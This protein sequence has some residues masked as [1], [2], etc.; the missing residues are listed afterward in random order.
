MKFTQRSSRVAF[1]AAFCL[2]VMV[3]D[4]RAETPAAVCNQVRFQPNWGGEKD[5]VGGKI[6]G[7]NVSSQTGFVTLAEIKEAPKLKEWGEVKF[8]NTKVY[9]Y[10]RVALP[11]EGKGK[12]SKVEFYD[13][14]QLV[15]TDKMGLRLNYFYGDAPDDHIIGYDLREK[16]STRP[17]GFKPGNPDLTGPADVALTAADGAVIRYTL[18]GTMPTADHG[19]IYKTPIHVDQ[20]TTI[21]AVAILP[22]RAPSPPNGVTFLLPA[23]TKQGL[24]VASVGNSLTGITLNFWRYARTAGYKHTTYPFLRGG[25]LTR[26]LW[27][28]T[29]SEYAAELKEMEKT[30]PSLANGQPWDDFW[31]KIRKVD[32][33]T[34]QPRDFD[35]E[36]ETA[37]EVNFLKLFRQ[38]W[39]D[40]QPYLYCEW[41][42]LAR[43]RPSDKGTVPSFEM[44]KTFP[45][46]TWE[47]SMSAMLLYMEELQHRL[48]AAYPEGRPAH[49]IPAALAMG[50][51]KNK[52]DH[53]QF[54][55]AQPGEFYSL[56]FSDQVHPAENGAFL[57]D[58]TWYSMLYREP[59]E[60]KVLPVGTT[61]TPEQ[62]RAME[63][64]AWDVLKHYPDCGFYEEG[65]EP[66]GQPEFANDGRIITLKSSTPGAWFRYTLDGTKPTRTRGYVYCGA[67]S[68][69]P[70]IH[71]QAIAYKSGMADSAVADAGQK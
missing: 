4:S 29:S 30:R 51:V 69:Q 8:D 65:K 15:A 22:D 59:S 45:A 28:L 40:L 63:Q 12:L 41:V 14:G 32:V 53:G 9:R 1:F 16:G 54:P 70:G 26:E 35:L 27:A 56:L 67:I 7:S 33:F 47:E 48:A 6:E 37:A 23:S 13:G 64:L 24:A 58:M 19:G 39:P 52:I 20:N 25:A 36:K 50:W 18:D 17:P 42:E 46:L 21:N 34:L 10:L 38:K 66:C 60:G 11:H 2:A 62:A 44:Q 5:I 68:V 31:Q 43:Q 49:I 57:V 55:G 61:L 3:A 71:V